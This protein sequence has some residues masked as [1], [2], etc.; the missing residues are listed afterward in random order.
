[1]NRREFL[2]G[3]PAL[4]VAAPSPPAGLGFRFEDVTARAGIAFQHNNGAFGGKLLGAGGG[5]FLLFIAPQDAQ[6]RLR[7]ALSELREIDFEFDFSGS[8]IVYVGDPTHS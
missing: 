7:A 8:R 5:G 1:M 6:P 3:L 2:L 4:A